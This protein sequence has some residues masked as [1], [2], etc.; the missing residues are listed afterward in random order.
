MGEEWKTLTI[1]G[2]DYEVSNTGKV[3]GLGRN[4]ELKQRYTNDGYLEVTVGKEKEGRTSKRVHTLVAL[5]FLEKPNNYD[6]FEV[7]H[8][9]LNRENNNADNLEWVTHQNNITYSAD[10]GRYKGRVGELNP[11][12]GNDTLKKKF[13]ENP[14]LKK[15]QARH[16][17]QNGRCIKV[18]MI[19]M[20]NNQEYYFNFMGECAEFLKENYN[21]KSTI[22]SLRITIR[23]RIDNGEL[24]RKRFKFIEV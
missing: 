1:L 3:K 9:D 24:Y 19:D 8:K 20:N 12:Y 5:T 14:E 10:L 6:I 15:L 16:K 4:K 2:L 21:I 11:N 22:N 7:N 13:I 17:E 18:K 23:K